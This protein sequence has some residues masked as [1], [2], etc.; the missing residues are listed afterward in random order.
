MENTNVAFFLEHWQKVRE[1]TARVARCI[2]PDKIEWT[3]RPDRFTLGDLLRHLAGIERYMYGENVQFRRSRYPGHGRELADGFDAVFAYF[4]RLHDESLEIFGRLT[5]DDLLKKCAT[6][7]GAPITVWKWLRAMVEHEAHHRGQIY[8]YLAM[9]DVPTP[10][11]Y[12]LTEEEV[13]KRSAPPA[14][15]EGR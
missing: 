13:R 3:M 2:P 5:D 7:G 6:V 15:E 14:R 1:R 11:L 8:L 10:P 4:S 12:G 9:L